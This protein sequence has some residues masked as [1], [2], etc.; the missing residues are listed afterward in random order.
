MSAIRVP[1]RKRVKMRILRQPEVTRY[2]N[3]NT[4]GYLVHIHYVFMQNKI[5][6]KMRSIHLVQFKNT[7]YFISLCLGKH[8]SCVA[9]EELLSYASCKPRVVPCFSGNMSIV[10]VSNTQYTEYLTRCYRY[11]MELHWKSIYGCI[12]KVHITHLSWRVV[13]VLVKAAMYIKYLH[14]KRHT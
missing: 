10:F 14:S 5:S 12:L 1:H 4:S 6:L 8:A 3:E 7:L 9:W 2:T 13:Y 11:S